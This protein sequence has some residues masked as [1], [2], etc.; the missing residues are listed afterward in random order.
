MTQKEKAEMLKET[1]S[2]LYE[3]ESRGKAYI[4]RLLQI[5]RNVLSKMMDSWNLIKGDMKHLPPS[6]EK[7]LKAN[8]S[9]ILNML[10][11]DSFRIEDI[12]RELDIAKRIL[13][14]SF[15]RSDKE[16][17]HHYM[18]KKQKS[19]ENAHE[20]L[21]FD[22]LDG[23]IWKDILGYP[24]YQISNMGRVCSCMRNNSRYIIRQN[25]NVKTGRMYVHLY[26]GGKRK[27]LSVSRIVGHAFVDGFSDVQNTIN[28]INKD[29]KDNK[30]ENLEWISQKE[31]NKKA[32][33]LGRSCAKGYSRNGK[34]KEIILDGKYRFKTIEALSRFLNISPT[35]VQRYI[36]K[37]TH[38]NHTF[39]FVY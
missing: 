33:E 20:K 2:F 18:L 39:D 30:S 22:T 16:L 1:I 21:S 8:R 4:S 35:Q 24:G 25:E 38:S 36:H 26:S 7:F 3:K 23:E 29:V 5:N 31:N 11:D 32:Y 28:H 14:D 17:F 6:K 10:S 12:A 27:A 13:V 9:K 34:F 19:A 37:E 15:I